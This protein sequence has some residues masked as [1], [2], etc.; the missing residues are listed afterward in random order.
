MAGED[1]RQ[2][3]RVVGRG[4]VEEELGDDLEVLDRVVGAAA[5]LRVVVG[6]VVDAAPRADLVP[7]LLDRGGDERV[8]AEPPVPRR[9]ARAGRLDGLKGVERLH[10]T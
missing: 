4:L 5:V 3:A 6:V 1:Q 2:V 8:L 7:D 10:R 9:A